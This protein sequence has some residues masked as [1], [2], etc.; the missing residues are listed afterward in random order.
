MSFS[1]PGI[2]A[3]LNYRVPITRQEVIDILL[4]GLHRL[5]YRGYDSAGLAFDVAAPMRNGTVNGT[6][7]MGSQ[8]AVIRQK[9]KVSALVKA[10]KG[11]CSGCTFI[12]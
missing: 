6:I 3:Y 8:I 4:S 5:E 2:F 7:D 12:C 9:G 10:V 1:S 11:K